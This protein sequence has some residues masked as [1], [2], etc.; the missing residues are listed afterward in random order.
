[1]LGLKLLPERSLIIGRRRIVAGL[2]G[3]TETP[4][5]IPGSNKDG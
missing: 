2:S 3:G 4:D 5:G 1:M